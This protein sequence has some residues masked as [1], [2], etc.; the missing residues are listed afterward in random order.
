M[1]K[2]RPSSVPSTGDLRAQQQCGDDRGIDHQ[3]ETG[4]DFDDRGRRRGVFRSVLRL[5]SLTGDCPNSFPPRMSLWEVR[6]STAAPHG[7]TP[8]IR[9]L[10]DPS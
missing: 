6:G 10:P 1:P 7:A 4:A 8:P 9:P 2:H 5:V 3:D